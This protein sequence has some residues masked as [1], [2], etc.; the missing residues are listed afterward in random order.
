MGKF[1]I[2]PILSSVVFFMLMI[3]NAFSDPI[4]TVQDLIVDKYVSG[5][6]CTVTT[7]TFVGDDIL[8]LQKS[9]GVVRLIKDGVLQE[10]PV[11]DVDVNSIGERGML[12][13]ASVDFSVYLYFTKANA[14]GD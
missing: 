7:M 9:D 4:L 10:K 5:L 6:C 3:P 2:I 1:F 14:D 13:I 8:I 11:L 12:G